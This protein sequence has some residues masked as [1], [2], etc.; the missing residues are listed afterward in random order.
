MWEAVQR[1]FGGYGLWGVDLVESLV[2]SV[3]PRG[4]SNETVVEE[5]M[6]RGAVG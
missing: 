2:G 6:H 4:E 3:C 5:T 1:E